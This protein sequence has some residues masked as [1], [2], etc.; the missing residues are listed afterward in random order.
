MAHN[1][2][3]PLNNRVFTVLVTTARSQISPLSFIVVQIPVDISR[4]GTALYSNGRHKTDG[5]TSQKR[6]DVQIGE[7]V[8]IERCELIESN[9]RIKWQM[10]TASDAKGVLPI[11]IQKMAV[12]GSVVKDVGFFIDWTQKRRSST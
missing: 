10:A 2:P 12:P 9:S 8:S 7:Y 3:P 6:K 11:S 4:I 1:I 5:D